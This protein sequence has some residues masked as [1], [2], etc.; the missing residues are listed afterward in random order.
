[1]APPAQPQSPEIIVKEWVRPGDI[2]WF[3]VG[4][5]MIATTVWVQVNV[6]TGDLVPVG[7]DSAYPQYVDTHRSPLL[8]PPL[9][10]LAIVS[11]KFG[12]QLASPLAARLDQGGIKLFAEIRF[13]LRMKV[14]AP[15]AEAPWDAIKRVVLRRRRSQ[16]LKFIPVWTTMLSF[17]R[18][19]GR[20]YGQS[21]SLSPWSVRKVAAGI[22]RFAPHVEFVDE[23]NPGKRRVI[24]P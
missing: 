16:L 1:M 23:R 9:L 11:V 4:V 7:N 24:T 17:E 18:P 5:A 8:V 22:S 6:P 13:G 12:S 10:V 21:A 15:K 2:L 3:A 19:S 14:G 20:R